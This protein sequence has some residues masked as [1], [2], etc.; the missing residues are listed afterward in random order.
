MLKLEKKNEVEDETNG[1]GGTCGTPGGGR[2]GGGEAVAEEARGEGA[3]RAATV[4][5]RAETWATAM[6][7][8]AAASRPRPPSV[9]AR[10]GAPSRPPP[11]AVVHRPSLRAPPQP[12]AR[13]PRPPPHATIHRPSLRTAIHRPPPRADINRPSLRAPPQ[14]PAPELAPPPPPPLATRA[15]AAT[16]RS[17]GA[18]VNGEEVGD[19]EAT[20]GH[21]SSLHLCRWPRAPPPPLSPAQR[22]PPPTSVCAAT[23][24]S[25]LPPFW[26]LSCSSSVASVCAGWPPLRARRGGGEIGG[27]LR[28]L[29]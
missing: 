12:P 11:C 7:G 9:P 18:T 1:A 19:G 4:E 29:P 27:E 17:S 5:A 10:P 26:A 21:P 15:T 24:L 14:P 28:Y 22:C 2:R 16:P 20:V 25:S 3:V 13:L 8:A 23:P 6:N